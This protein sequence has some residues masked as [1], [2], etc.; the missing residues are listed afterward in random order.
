MNGF[1]DPT[2]IPGDPPSVVCREFEEA[3]QR[4]LMGGRP[5]TINEFL[6]RSGDPTTLRAILETIETDYRKR[7]SRL[8]SIEAAGVLGGDDS[9]PPP[10]ADGTIVIDDVP[11]VDPNS[12]AVV[13]AADTSPEQ[14]VLVPVLNADPGATIGS[15]L[16]LEPPL[17][18]NISELNRTKRR[19]AVP[20][21]VVVPGYE[22][23]GVLGRG[24]MGVVYKARHLRLKRTVALKMV[25]AGVHAS[26]NDLARFFIEAEA[27]AQLQH[28]NIV[29]VYE[30]GDHD[31]LPFFA[32]EFV[33][34][35]S[36]QGRL[37][38]KPQPPREAARL[39]ETLARAMAYAHLNGIIHR[40]LKPANVLMAGDGQPKITDFGLAKKLEGDSGQTKSGTL[41]GTP[42][43][44]A[45]EQARGDTKEVG[46]LADVYSIGVILY[47][48]LTGRTPFAGTSILDTLRQV[49][50][51]EPVP[52]RRLQPTVPADLDTIVLKCLQK[53]PAKRYAAADAFADDLRRF[54]ADQPIQARPVG[55]AER[56]W[57][58]CRRNPRVA[59][60]STAVLLLLV[61][62]AITST[63]LAIRI[64]AEHSAAVTARDEAIAAG[65]LAEKNAAAEKAAREV[66]DQ[67]AGLALKTI[68]SLIQQ[69]VEVQLGNEPR[70][71][72]LKIEL[73]KTALDG[74]GQADQR[75]EAVTR[76]FIQTTMAKAYYN[77]GSI[78][79]QLGDTEEAFKQFLR[80]AEIF[81]ARAA[82]QPTRD[83]TQGNLAAMFSLLGEMSEERGRDMTAALGYY[84]QALAIREQ[85]YRHP[86]GGDGKLD[87]QVV[88]ATLAEAYTRVGV[89]L[90][91][92]GDPAASLAPFQ[93]ALALRKELAEGNPANE[94]MQQ[95][96]AWTY[97]ALGE[98]GSLTRDQ[99]A[100]KTYYEMCLKVFEASYKAHPESANSKRQ[101]AAAIGN[102]GDLLVRTGDFGSARKQ[103]DR[104][105]ALSRALSDAD[106]QNAEARR[107]LAAALYRL[108]T[109]SWLVKD[110]AGAKD[111]FGECLR[112]REDL[113]AKD[114]ANNRR[115]VD[116]M[117]VLP[118]CGQ[119]A[120][121]AEIAGKL[122]AGKPDA[123]LLL[124]IACGYA[125][126]AD[127]VA[128]EK[129]LR[130]R[131][132]AAAVAALTDAVAQGYTDAVTLE[133][134]PDLRPL[135]DDMAYQAL[136]AKV[137][138]A[139]EAK[140]AKAREAGGK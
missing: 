51:Q 28:P 7:I 85:L 22:V 8:C 29:Q 126:C 103:F 76:T 31:G 15:D 17:T 36:L 108:G 58:W 34:G 100:A 40:D 129:P 56:A 90:L 73:L 115:Q 128:A 49:Q 125:L 59:G 96:L 2:A 122:R 3:W 97:N 33:D 47:E 35:G 42:N 106:P 9:G 121:A 38:G 68:Q 18:Q 67:Q 65:E 109:L 80:A 105:L 140:A 21:S 132:T 24:G 83:A 61:T 139:A 138:A 11:V 87:P 74:L 124:D 52:P 53:D 110:A 46:P 39:A 119:H 88:K 23:L 14:T 41:M 32:L 113:L 10:A 19:R 136:L 16:E 63:V 69:V 20:E 55:P 45:P 127:A 116:V 77:M 102:F 60:L 94:K 118:R 26:A 99:P 120:R 111:R 37:A 114:A 27:I 66:A 93:S 79:R 89:T 84:H 107:D 57:R 81:K 133:T 92:L 91:R 134:E 4:A 50:H 123:E 137:R 70:T 135:R 1:P 54:L 62:V 82:A 25:L 30:I 130:D 43:Y 64:A 104:S 112:I 13:A 98:V 72:H 12:T 44:M 6:A 71:Q 48:M 131:Y 117:R 86:H 101:L 75:A 5:P 95:D 78:F